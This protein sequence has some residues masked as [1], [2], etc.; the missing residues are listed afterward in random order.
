LNWIE[1]AVAETGSRLLRGPQVTAL[2]RL[3]LS[4]SLEY[5]IQITGFAAEACPRR[6]GAC[7]KAGPAEINSRETTR[8][9][10]ICPAY[11]A[12]RQT[13]FAGRREYYGTR[14]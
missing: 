2:Q 12:A 13:A 1:A 4:S 8:F 14:V 10:T 11:V 3:L 6:R 5:A 9:R 7:R